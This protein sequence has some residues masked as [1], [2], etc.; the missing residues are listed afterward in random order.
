MSVGKEPAVWLPET[1]VA[2]CCR[3]VRRRG[4]GSNGSATGVEGFALNAGRSSEPVTVGGEPAQWWQKRRLQ[5]RIRGGCLSSSN[6]REGG[7][8][9]EASGVRTLMAAMPSGGGYSHLAGEEE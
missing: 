8:A 9:V 4:E 5:M 2:G 3:W 7:G 6:R 1:K